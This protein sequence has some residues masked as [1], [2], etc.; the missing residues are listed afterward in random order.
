LG[1]R[2]YLG[3]RGETLF[4]AVK[5]PAKITIED[6]C[7]RELKS[8]NLSRGD[9]A[10][11]SLPENASQLRISSDPRKG[12]D[13]YDLKRAGGAIKNG[14]KRLLKRRASPDSTV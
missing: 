1:K 13:V 2:V 12:A 11:L 5:G 8:V 7:G 3:K 6:D 10:A 14:E 9:D 4:I